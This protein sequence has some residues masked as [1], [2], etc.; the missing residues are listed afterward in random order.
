MQKQFELWPKHNQENQKCSG[1]LVGWVAVY[2]PLLSE[3]KKAKYLEE[4]KKFKNLDIVHIQ[5]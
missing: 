4:A 1:L 2:D 5:P 3:R